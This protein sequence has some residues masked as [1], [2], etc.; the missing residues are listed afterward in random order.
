METRTRLLDT[1]GPLFAQ[2][3]FRDLGVKQICD[4]AG[5]NVAAVNYHFGSKQDF[6]AAVL[7]HAHRSAFAGDPMPTPE[8]GES[9]ALQLE[10]WLGWWIR[11]MLH[12]D[13]PSWVQTLMTREMVDPTPALDQMV[14]RSIRPMYEALT[15][16]IR[17][18]LPKGSKAATV[19][20][21]V[22]SVIGQVIFYKHAA[23]VL[24]RLGT[25]PEPT[26][27]ALER[28]VAHV[29]AFSLAGVMAAGAATKRAQRRGTP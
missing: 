13:R 5:C 18:L 20:D 29:V 7:E 14:E 4:S 6:Y 17:R 16:M 22:H 15:A 9:P 26:P 21:C 23:P 24:Q 10:R 12:P 11:G 8:R 3:G 1:A 27:R 25:A 28:L 19:R 2:H